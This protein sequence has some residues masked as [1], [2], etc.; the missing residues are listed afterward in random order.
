[1]V[2][3]TSILNT[4][5]STSNLKV[6]RYSNVSDLPNN[7]SQIGN[8]AY[9]NGNYYGYNGSWYILGST[10]AN[11]DITNVY[12]PDTVSPLPDDFFAPLNQTTVFENTSV[13]PLDFT[14]FL[15]DPTELPLET[16]ISL[17]SLTTDSITVECP[18]ISDSIVYRDVA[19]SNAPTIDGDFIISPGG[20]ANVSSGIKLVVL[21][22]TTG[23]GPARRWHSVS[24]F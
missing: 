19:N 18:F 9:V 13:L 1:M 15:Q 5:V 20:S 4:L 7:D 6:P 12:K 8:I 24:Q 2:F 21:E 16:S 3:K 23:S 10:G 14:V 11:V 22:N 17:V